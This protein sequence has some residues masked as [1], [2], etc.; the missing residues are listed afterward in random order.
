MNWQELTI[1]SRSE[2]GPAR[3]LNEDSCIADEVPSQPGA[4]SARAFLAAVA[5]GAGGHSAGEV[6][7]RLALSTLRSSLAAA[8]VPPEQALQHAFSAANRAVY[9]RA[10]ADAGDMCTTLT[11]VLITD[12]GAWVG[13]VGDTRLYLLRNGRVRQVTEDDTWVGEQLRSGALREDAARDMPQRHLLTLAVGSSAQLT[14]QPTHLEVQ[15]G[16][17]L[18][19]CSD[20]VH[21]ALDEAEIAAASRRATAPQPF[22]DALTRLAEANDGSDNM[23]AVVVQFG[24]VPAPPP[25]RRLDITP[26]V[27]ASRRK[28]RARLAL[29]VIAVAAVLIAGA[30]WWI[31]VRPREPRPA[32]GGSPSVSREEGARAD[33]TRRSSEKQQQRP[34]R[35]PAP[36]PE[37]QAE[38]PA[39]KASPS[40]PVTP[41]AET[42]PSSRDPQRA[43]E[44]PPTDRSGDESDTAAAPQDKTKSAQAAEGPEKSE[45]P[46]P[47]AG[48]EAERQDEPSSDSDPAPPGETTEGGP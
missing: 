27:S 33:Q 36:D 23:T 2:P 46:K 26:L 13:H 22:A 32:A 43:A 18:L 19:L 44:R 17:R 48:E 6:A 38:P 7:S 8:T 35:A 9:E 24:A 31:S 34:V 28:R 39:D 1:G 45:T 5:D 37:E 41:P 42:A 10:R 12:R 11:A 29:K 16:D 3:P 14:I 4:S 40:A 21:G 25:T 47:A 15:S 20:G 30:Y